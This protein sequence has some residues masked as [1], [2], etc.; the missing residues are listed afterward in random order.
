MSGRAR[1]GRLLAGVCRARLGRPIGLPACAALGRPM[2]RRGFDGI[3]A[4][5]P[6][7]PVTLADDAKAKKNSDKPPK[8]RG[9]GLGPL[10]GGEHP[11]APDNY[12]G[13]DPGALA[14]LPAGP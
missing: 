9:A 8:L 5:D 10:V 14:R 13:Q 3:E 1:N 6:S 2:L 11:P 7:D 4:A 12:G